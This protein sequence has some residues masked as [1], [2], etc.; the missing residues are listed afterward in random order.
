MGQCG[1]NLSRLQP[2]GVIGVEVGKHDKGGAIEDVGGRGPA[3]DK[4]VEYVVHFS[5]LLTCGTPIV[6]ILYS[7]RE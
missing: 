6:V 1:N 5:F 2:R 7:W 3:P 4:R